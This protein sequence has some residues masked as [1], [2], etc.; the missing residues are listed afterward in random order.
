MRI[1][2]VCLGNICRSPLAEGL[3]R[4]HSQGLNLLLDS[5]GTSSNHAGEAPD[6]RTR[7][8]ALQNGLN[9]EDLRARQFSKTDFQHFD[10]IFVMDKSNLRHVLSMSEHDEER[11]KVQ[12]LLEEVFP[13]SNAEVPDPW[14]GGEE[15]FQ[16]VFEML[17]EA[18]RLLA[19]KIRLEYQ[20]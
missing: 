5:A 7:R 1:L 4:K 3:L 15:G 17:D 10:R 11:R 14:Y 16:Q 8:N 12:L 9:I 19:E 18:C 20:H 13:G 2:L 6:P